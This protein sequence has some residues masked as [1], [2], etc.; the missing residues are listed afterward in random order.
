MRE[1]TAHRASGDSANNAVHITAQ[2]E[3]AGPHTYRLQCGAK[4][5]FLEFSRGDDGEGLTDEALAAVL[6]DR[7][8]ARPGQENDNARASI[9]NAMG[10]IA[11]RT[12]SRMGR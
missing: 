4:D 2:D 11:A 1:I 6:M 3:P 9:Q 10:W 5:V 7:L 8:A 12:R